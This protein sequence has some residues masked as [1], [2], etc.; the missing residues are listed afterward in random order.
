MKKFAQWPVRL[1]WSAAVLS[2]VAGCASYQ[3]KEYTADDRCR[4]C[5]DGGGIIS[6]EDG[7]LSYEL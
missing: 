7:V 5:G 1:I 2:L 4:D 6:G 3:L